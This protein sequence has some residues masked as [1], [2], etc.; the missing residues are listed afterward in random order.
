ME[1]LDVIDTPTGNRIVTCVYEGRKDYVSVP[2]RKWLGDTIM[3]CI[4][5]E[6]YT[7]SEALGFPLTDDWVDVGG[8]T[9]GEWA[10]RLWHAVVQD[11][12]EEAEI[13]LL[14]KDDE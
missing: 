11:S 4:R 8:S 13:F 12:A 9:R 3:V 2:F 6:Y 7:L 1:L 10:G 14:G 5:G